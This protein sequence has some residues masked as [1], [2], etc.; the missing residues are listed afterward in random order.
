MFLLMV[1][2]TCGQSLRHQLIVSYSGQDAA[3]IYT[4]RFHALHNRSTHTLT[5]AIL[6]AT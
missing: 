1:L 2:F 3:A 4:N 6:G 5:Q